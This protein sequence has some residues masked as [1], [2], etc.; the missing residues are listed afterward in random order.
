[1]KRGGQPILERRISDVKI[2][3]PLDPTLFRRP[4]P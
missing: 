3:S 4:T 1:V 2:N